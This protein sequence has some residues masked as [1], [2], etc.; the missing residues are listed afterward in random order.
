MLSALDQV[1][2]HI[3]EGL[4]SLAKEIKEIKLSLESS[5]RMSMAVPAPQGPPVS[6]K[7]PVLPPSPRQAPTESQLQTAAQQVIEMKRKLSTGDTSSGKPSAPLAA[8]A[9]SVELVSPTTSTQSTSEARVL[10]MANDLK[11]SFEEIQNARREIGIL[12]QVY[13][14]FKADTT[15]M[16]GSLK[17]Q[18]DKVK[19]LANT[20]VAGSRVYID[21]GKAKLDQSSQDLLTKIEELQDIID[22]LKNDVTTRRIRPKPQQMDN[23]KKLIDARQAELSEL[24][25][26][27][28]TV[29]PMW[30]KTWETELQNIVD[31][32]GLL[33]HQE[34]LLAD[35]QSDHESV[36]TIFGQLQQ[37]LAL[38]QG[39]KGRK[40]EY[41]PPSPEQGHGGLKTVMLEVKG[42]Q[43]DPDKR[44]KAIEQAE[45]A[46]QRDASSK[47]NEFANEL[48]G[49]VEKGKLRKT[50]AWC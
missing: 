47:T 3:D 25:K 4:S 40:S 11:V 21:T 30:K 36:V 23:I 12:R 46:R 2:Q 43:P 33:N 49:F 22:D 20:Q 1:K 31:E 9:H 48:G 44:L 32:Q 15:S 27:I 29:K 13:A 28:N 39:A 6:D 35:L 26:Y 18:T 50:G 42:L 8:A 34:E 41:R 37:Y 17:S 38:R 19:D 24:G 7:S 14:D 16:L 5:R 45:K 10:R